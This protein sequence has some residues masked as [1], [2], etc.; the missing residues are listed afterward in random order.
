[1]KNSIHLI[2]I[3]LLCMLQLVAQERNKDWPQMDGFA[4]RQCWVDNDFNPPF[5]LVQSINVETRVDK[6]TYMDSVVYFG[7]PQGNNFYGALDL[8]TEQLLWSFAVPGSSGA[9]GTVP[10]LSEDL[11]YLGGQRGTGLYALDRTSGDSVWFQPA[12][13]LFGRSP[14]IQGEHLY[15]NLGG[16]PFTC[17]NKYSGELQ[18]TFDQAVLQYT[19]VVDSDQVYYYS[20][21]DTVYALNR[22][23]GS[24]NWKTH[25]PLNGYLFGMMVHDGQFVIHA[26]RH[27]VIFNKDDGNL[28][29]EFPL[30][31]STVLELGINT[32][33]LTPDSYLLQGW[34]GERTDSFLVCRM[35]RSDGVVMWNQKLGPESWVSPVA[36]GNHFVVL[37]HR[38]VE[39]R[40]IES[41]E[42]LQILSDKRF[43]NRP[44]ILVTELGI[45]AADSTFINIY[46]PAS[47][48]T[49]IKMQEGDS[50]RWSVQ[51]NPVREF[52]NLEIHSTAAKRINWKVSDL[53]GR[54]INQQQ[55]L[56]VH[57]G[58]QV[59]SIPAHWSPGYY[60][61]TLED[62][63]FL[64]SRKIIVPERY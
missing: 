11:V 20:R 33:A 15:I 32:M 23:T 3:F 9:V 24:V 61:I 59:L 36:F 22:F 4:D 55:A 41:G 17:F 31:D 45:I 27:V 37:S 60:I 35:R 40:S 34:T 56:H 7:S 57:P 47:P 44:R 54:I 13:S 6:L 19:P 10:V 26:K 46:A 53:N 52:L 63:T 21:Q 8:T 25:Y 1:M 58:K 18:W 12:G 49:S 14:A 28:L 5:D 42:I 51:N 29:N 43:N 64:D 39:I 50:F 38:D 2:A 16:Q 62:E 48:T 30:P